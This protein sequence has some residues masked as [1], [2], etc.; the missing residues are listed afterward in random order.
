MVVVPTDLADQSAVTAA[1][2]HVKNECGAIDILVNNA[3]VVQP[4][5]PT[6]LISRLAGDTTGQIWDVDEEAPRP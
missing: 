6:A 5:G 3:A 4:M 1:I 2:Q